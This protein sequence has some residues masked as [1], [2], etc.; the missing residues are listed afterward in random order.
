MDIIS[1]PRLICFAHI[2]STWNLLR[3]RHD[4]SKVPLSLAN[5]YTAA[6]GETT[7]TTVKILKKGQ[8]TAL[9]LYKEYVYVVFGHFSVK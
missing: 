8:V 6:I 7:S 3:E 4:F 5:P 9:Y 1:G 2:I